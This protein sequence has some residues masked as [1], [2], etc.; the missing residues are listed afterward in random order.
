MSLRDVFGTDVLI[1]GWGHSPFGKLTDDSL[2]SL[3][4]AVARDALDNAGVEPA[5]VDEIF[6][7]QFN[8]GMHPLGFAS[9]LALQLSDSLAGVPATRVENACASGSAAVAQGVRSLLAGTANTVLVIGADRRLRTRQRLPARSQAGSDRV[10]RRRRRR[11]TRDGD[12]R[13]HDRR[14]RLRR[15]P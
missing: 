12:G 14:S 13:H 3:I 9:S 4:V 10:R 1:S 5:D 7:G 2:E 11:G 6:L 15:G 8:S